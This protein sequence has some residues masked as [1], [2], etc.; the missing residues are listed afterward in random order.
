[1]VAAGPGDDKTVAAVRR[2]HMR[3]SHAD[4]EQLTDV[5]KAAFVQGRLTKEE[6]DARIGQTFTARTY[7]ELAA[8]IADLP[9]ELAGAQLPRPPS[10]RPAGSVRRWS[11]AG[12][13]TPAMVAVAF[14]FASLPGDGG[15]AVAANMIAF[16]YFMFWLSAGANL[17]CAPRVRD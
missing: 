1:M 2:G 7:G 17:L 4:R 14:V 8:V 5:L 3:A 13:I 11:A 6:F 12:L 9:A 15:L 10:P 16:G